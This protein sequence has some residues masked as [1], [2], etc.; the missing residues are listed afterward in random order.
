MEK[1]GGGSRGGGEGERRGEERR[2]EGERKE[3]QRL[4]G[5]GENTLIYIKG[6]RKKNGQ[7]KSATVALATSELS[8]TDAIV[9][10][11]RVEGVR[12]VR[13]VP[14]NFSELL[15]VPVEERQVRELSAGAAVLAIV[16][17]AAAASAQEAPGREDCS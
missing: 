16:A 15:L 9:D 1:E 8:L 2:G 3:S 17:L 14:L 11:V 5:D 7:D 13:I 6:R 4:E 10:V 12:Q